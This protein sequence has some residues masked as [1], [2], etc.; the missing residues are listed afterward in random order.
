M[1][2]FHEYVYIP[3]IHKDMVWSCDPRDQIPPRIEDCEE[4]V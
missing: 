3:D 2:K 4:L 1:N